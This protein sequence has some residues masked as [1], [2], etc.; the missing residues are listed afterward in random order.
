MVLRNGLPVFQYLYSDIDPVARQVAQ[1]R[2][3]LLQAR[4]PG[5]LPASALEHTFSALPQDVWQVTTEQLALLSQR[6]PRQWLVVGGWECQDLSPA[7]ASRGLTGSRS[8]T[9]APLVKILADLQQLQQHLPP[10]YLVENV[11]MQHNPAQHIREQF[12]IISKSLGQPVCLDATQFNSL[13]HRVR[14][15]WTNLCSQQQLESAARQV[16]RTPGL[17]VQSVISPAAS[18]FAAPVQQQDSSRAGRYPA[19]FVGQPRSAWPT[20]MAYKGSRAFKEGQPGAILDSAG[21]R[22]DEPTAAEREAAMGYTPG[23]TQAPGVSEQQRREILGRCIEAHVLQAI[24]AIAAAWYRQDCWRP[25]K[26]QQFL[27][28]SDI[29]LP[30]SKQAGSWVAAALAATTECVAF[31]QRVACLWS[32]SGLKPDLGLAFWWK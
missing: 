15:Y 2:L 25:G 12:G 1:H 16:Q 24:M 10:A 19:N 20:L 6:W 9:L 8:S 14:N 11:A 3:A 13:A 17:T 18:R 4:Y 29:E 32:K 28:A 30:R 22:V 31:G 26:Q 27:A 7:G 23:D 5:L 21:N